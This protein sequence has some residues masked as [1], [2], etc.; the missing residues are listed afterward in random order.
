MQIRIRTVI[1]VRKREF[2]QGYAADGLHT[3]I[4]FGLFDGVRDRAHGDAGEN[5]DDADNH[6]EFDE[7]ETASTGKAGGTTGSETVLEHG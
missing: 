7:G 5:R 4:L 3:G 1:V 2:G 6:K